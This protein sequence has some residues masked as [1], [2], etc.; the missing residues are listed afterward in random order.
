MICLK[1]E[2]FNH[3]VSARSGKLCLKI[4]A[5]NRHTQFCIFL[6]F[7]FY[8]VSDQTCLCSLF[9]SQPGDIVVDKTAETTIRVAVKKA[10]WTVISAQYPYL[11]YTVN[12]DQ[13]KYCDLS[14]LNTTHYF[15]TIHNAKPARQ[16]TL[17]FY[18]CRWF[19]LYCTVLTTQSVWIPPKSEFLFF[20][21]CVSA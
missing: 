9:A 7:I 17:R 19:K 15:C 21:E 14:V 11:Y 6:A 13:R 8:S 1:E 20:I 12:H 10:K 5:F 18:A 2:G 3:K 16:H 4:L